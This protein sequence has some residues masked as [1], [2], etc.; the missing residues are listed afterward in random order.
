MSRTRRT[1][2]D[3]DG[4]VIAD[5]SAV[6]RPP[7]ILPRRQKK[8]EAERPPEAEDRP[9]ESSFTPQERRVTILAA[10]KAGLLIALT[11]IVGLGAIIL[12]LLWLWT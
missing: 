8:K 6:E 5:M 7:L 10:L 11:Y 1:Y 2:D 9:W 4:R 12:L 3:D